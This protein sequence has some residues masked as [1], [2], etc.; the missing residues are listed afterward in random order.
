M[1]QFMSGETHVKIGLISTITISILCAKQGM[2]LKTD[3]NLIPILMIP[4]SYLGSLIPDID[5]KQSKINS[6]L[7]KQKKSIRTWILLFICLLFIFPKQNNTFWLIAILSIMLVISFIDISKHMSH[8][9]MLT[10]SNMIPIVLMIFASRHN[11]IIKTFVF[12]FAIGWISHIIAD[13]F[14]SKGTYLL[15]PIPLK[16]HLASIKSNSDEENIFLIIVIVIAIA[17]CIIL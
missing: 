4:P 8:R 7:D 17:L 2:I 15:A 3:T 5:I 14:N 1:R 12:G 10:H 11:I 6:V 9:N 16:I 13:T